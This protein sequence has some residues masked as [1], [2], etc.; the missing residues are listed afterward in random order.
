MTRDISAGSEL[1]ADKLAA[2][3]LKSDKLRLIIVMGLPASGKSTLAEKLEAQGAKRVNRDA[4]R[5]RLYGDEA[6]QGDYKKV[7]EE[8]Y[9]ELREALSDGGPV[10]SDNVN[11]TVA[12][13]RDTIEAGIQAGYTDIAVVWVS[14]PLDVC[15]ERNSKRDR[16]VGEDIIRG[17]HSS[18]VKDGLPRENEGD[19]V[20][21]LNGKDREHYVVESVRAGKAE[22]PAPR[23][24]KPR[25]K[26]A[27]EKPAADDKSAPDAPA[28]AKT[29]P[30][31]KS[32]SEGDSD[33]VVKAPTVTQKRKLAGD[34]RTQADL[35]DQCL[36]AGRDEWA[37][38]TLGVLQDLVASGIVTLSGT[39][40]KG[41]STGKA[42]AG[43]TASGGTTSKPPAKTPWIPPSAAEVQETLLKMI[44]HRPHV[45]GEGPLVLLSFNGHLLTKEKAEHLVDPLVE[46]FKRAHAVFVQ[47]TNVDAM[48]VIAKAAR[49][50]MNASHRNERGQACGL[51]FHPR[52]QWLGKAPMYHDYLL[53]VPGH[54]EYKATLRP[55]LQ[56]RVRDLWSNTLIDLVNFHGKSNLGGPDQT[57]PVRQWQFE[58]FVAELERQKLKSPY[59][60]RQ[61]TGDTT[62][63]DG[64]TLSAFV[65]NSGYDLPLDA[66]VFGGDFNTPI[67][68]PTSTEIEPL[69]KAGF[70]RVSTPE[71]GWSYQYRGNGGQFDGFFVRDLKGKVLECFIPKFFPVENKRDTAFYRE[72]SDHLPVFTVLEMPAPATPANDATTK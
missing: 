17:M 38:Q 51:L 25:S 33:T 11:I 49:Y 29:T 62:G 68:N 10:V 18:L 44:G 1:A 67:E 6:I 72:I 54:P 12:H 14:V 30:K 23:V 60:A 8:Y 41:S 48:R 69:I 55:A 27:E 50:G 20:V 22:L 42:P 34:I 58:A 15:L 36:M 71:N 64:K 16:K 63:G 4:I 47:E 66:V 52:L 39:G 59:E 19:L 13:R 2:E 5:K 70:T 7:N 57:R 40:K 46:L 45:T 43:G 21:L 65:D 28:P 24:P 53:N 37:V 26:P 32:G 61:A 3:L 56:R 9:A 35:F 31:K